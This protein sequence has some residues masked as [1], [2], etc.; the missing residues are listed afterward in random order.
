L[1]FLY[2]GLGLAM[3]LPIM[4]G[5]QAAIFVSE[6]EPRESLIQGGDGKVFAKWN[7]DLDFKDNLS[8]GVSVEGFE[9]RPF[10]EGAA[11]SFCLVPQNSDEKCPEEY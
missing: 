11:Q 10:G 7:S 8:L 2:A 3:L 5:L 6:S 4:V 9:L 1:L